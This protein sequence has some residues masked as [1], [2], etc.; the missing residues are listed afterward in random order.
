[1]FVVHNNQ[2]CKVATGSV[3]SS[4]NSI[5]F[6]FYRFPGSKMLKK[7]KNLLKTNP[8][9]N[10]HEAT[11]ENPWFKYSKSLR[12]KISLSKFVTCHLKVIFPSKIKYLRICKIQWHQIQFKS[13]KEWLILKVFCNALF[14]K[15]DRILRFLRDWFCKIVH[16]C[17]PKILSFYF[18]CWHF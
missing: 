4:R 18:H 16:R 12:I 11:T 3:N 8:K 9:I 13:S 14:E 7:I 10:R 1:M 17:H 15:F 2:Y 6:D 5:N